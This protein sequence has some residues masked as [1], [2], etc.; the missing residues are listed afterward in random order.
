MEHLNV[1]SDSDF[2]LVFFVSTL[3]LTVLTES[4]FLDIERKLQEEILI[5]FSSRHLKTQSLIK[6]SIFL[7][8]YDFKN[9]PQI[10]A[11]YMTK[12]LYS[13]IEKKT[14]EQCLI[15]KKEISTRQSINL[16]VVVYFI[17]PFTNYRFHFQ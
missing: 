1:L 16:F 12:N 5:Q 7:L 6:K 8:L 17:F 4:L 14:S 10:G 2:V 3:A 15:E 9:R 13:Q 11:K